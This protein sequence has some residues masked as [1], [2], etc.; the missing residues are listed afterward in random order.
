MRWAQRKIGE[1]SVAQ[2]SSCRTCW[3]PGEGEVD[4]FDGTCQYIAGVGL[5]RTLILDGLFAN[6]HKSSAGML[7][8]TK[9]TLFCGFEC[10]VCCTHVSL[11]SKI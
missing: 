5:S 7:K 11:A 1:R 8:K 3:H 4:R 10:Q 9:P 6:N 2:P